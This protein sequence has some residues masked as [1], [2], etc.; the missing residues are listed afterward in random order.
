MAYPTMRRKPARIGD[1]QPGSTCAL[2]AVSGLPALSVP[3]GTTQRRAADR[4]RTARAGVRR[5][6]AA[7]A[8]LLVRAG[9]THAPAAIQ[10]A[11]AGQRPGARPQDFVV[12]VPVTGE[13]RGSG[14]PHGVPLRPDDRRVEVL[15]QLHG[16]SRRSGCSAPGSSAAA[17]ARRVPRCTRS[18]MRGELDASGVIQLPPAEHARLREGGFYLA[19]YTVGSPGGKARAQLPRTFGAQ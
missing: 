14:R 8:R 15:G 10:R 1:A 12:N 11:A 17:P 9:V 19:V 16:H 2:S 5:I 18:S 7:R 13:G 3:A 6:E 4:T